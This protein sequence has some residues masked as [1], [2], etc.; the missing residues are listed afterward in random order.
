[1]YVFSLCGFSVFSLCVFY[2]FSLCV[3]SVF[4]LCVFSVFSLCVFSVFYICFLCAL[5]VI[6]CLQKKGQQYKQNKLCFLNTARFSSAR[7]WPLEPSNIVVG[8]DVV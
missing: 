4:S 3:F 6:I 5:Y 1:M 2:V 7:H 8:G